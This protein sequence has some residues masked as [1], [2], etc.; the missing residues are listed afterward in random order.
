MNL[1]KK[2]EK[3]TAGMLLMETNPGRRYYH[4]LLHDYKS[5]PYNLHTFLSLSLFYVIRKSV[6]RKGKK[7]IFFER[8]KIYSRKKRSRVSVRLIFQTSDTYII[9]HDVSSFFL[10]S[11][12][13]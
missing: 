10:A 12:I 5:Y 11:F 6:S 3:F 2:K 7:K 1:K 4:R 9:S 13:L 8:H